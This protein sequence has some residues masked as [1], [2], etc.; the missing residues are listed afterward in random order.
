MT[1]R[2]HAGPA[3]PRWLPPLL[4]LALAGWLRCWRLGHGL[5]DFNEEAIP[6]KQ[7]LEM[8]LA[9]PGRIDWNPHFFNYPS[10]SIYLHFLVQ[11][12][13]FLVGKAA[14]QFASVADYELALFL[15]PTVPALLGR[16]L[17]V[18]C[19]LATIFFTWRLGERLRP[20]AGIWAALLVAMAPTAIDTSRQ[21][22]SDTVM[23]AL[24][25][26]ALERMA[27]CVLEGGRRRFLAAAALTGLAAGAKYP[28]GLL[29]LPLV[30][31]AWRR[32]GWLCWRWLALGGAVSLGSFLASSPYVALDFGSFLANFGSERTHMAEG[33]L[34]VI[35]RTGAGFLLRRAAGDLGV[36][37]L[38][39]VAAA[40]AASAVSVS[41]RNRA[42]ARM[43]PWLFLVPM[44]VSV[45]TFRMEAVRYVMPLLPPAAIIVGDAIGWAA[46]DRRAW[47]RFAG[48]ALGAAALIQVAAGG[49]PL[50]AA[51]A[52]TTQLQARAWF[53]AHAGRD[54]LVVQE[55]YGAKLVSFF[56]AKEIAGSPAYAAASEPLR[57][58]FDAL[59]RHRSVVLPMLVS[60]NYVVR[61]E[62][63]RGRSRTITAFEH[64]SDLVAAFYD[65]DL[66]R[67]V[68]FVLT[69]SAVRGRYAADPERYPAQN[70]LYAM[71]DRSATK[72]ARFSPRGSTA[73]PEI[74]IYRIGE[75]FRAE[76]DESGG[77]I[78][79]YWWTEPVPAEFRRRISG[80]V[81]GGDGACSP[82]GPDGGP[83]LWVQTLDELY[84]RRVLP[85]TLEMAL[86]NAE[87]G[88]LEPARALS[89]SI[90]AMRPDLGAAAMIH[91][92]SAA[93][94]GMWPEALRHLER[95][96][97]IVEGGS[98]LGTMLRLERA[99]CL[100]ALGRNVE[101]R[102]EL[103]AL[104][105]DPDPGGSGQARRMLERLEVRGG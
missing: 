18:A 5:P 27:A 83:A 81:G 2:N 26:A 78:G 85:F 66:F 75:R 25:I 35:G 68:D 47:L 29:V 88:R 91:A 3:L 80:R 98:P 16:S 103:R 14:G 31:T 8:W 9:E 32:Q 94:L 54:D 58:R 93:G 105:G 87:L 34:G 51:G 52:D 19:D 77:S 74:D 22:F 67:S 45:A 69:S 84:D 23:T 86:Y 97:S 61:L 11:Q 92:H 43:V 15:D 40:L 1:A 100:A 56:E 76:V 21:I 38:I 44:A 10:L 55:S 28:A 50:A 24:A 4:I 62:D 42:D 33:H 49:L 59:P 36:G 90:L 63:D 70:R 7:A 60:G 89:A 48:W 104:A 99:R 96:L 101:A 79:P 72:V 53:R 17:G 102:E 57:R 6:L 46:A 12:A 20:G 64:A 82:A 30:W 73:G 65:P 71:L 41:R 39:A 95:T 13:H 37:G